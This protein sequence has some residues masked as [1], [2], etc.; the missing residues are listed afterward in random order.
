MAQKLNVPKNTRNSGFTF[1]KFFVVYVGMK[2]KVE[3]L[4]ALAISLAN[5][6]MGI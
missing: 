3:K 1:K 5:E 2:E 4:A 6:H